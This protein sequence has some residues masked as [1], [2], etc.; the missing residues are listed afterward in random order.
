LE[1][2]Y[3]GPLGLYREA[4]L[5]AHFSP[6]IHVTRE[7]GSDHTAF[8]RLGMPAVGITEEYRNGDTTPHIHRPTDTWDTVDFEYLAA[9]TRLVQA[10]M[11]ILVGAR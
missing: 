6:Q 7:V 3:E 5:S 1:I 4:A 11:A 9:G 10:A 2:P 8:R